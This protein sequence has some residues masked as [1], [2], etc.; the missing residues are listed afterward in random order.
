MEP[1]YEPVAV[2]FG[3]YTARLKGNGI[4]SGFTAAVCAGAFRLSSALLEMDFL[5]LAAALVGL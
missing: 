1:G 2:E 3:F 4:L 5:P